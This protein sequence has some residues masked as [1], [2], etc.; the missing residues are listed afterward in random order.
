MINDV[1]SQVS[2]TAIQSK[3]NANEI[4]IKTLKQ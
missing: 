3:S 2:N 4:K 1:F